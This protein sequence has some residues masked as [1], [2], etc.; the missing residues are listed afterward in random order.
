MTSGHIRS[1]PPP[2]FALAHAICTKALRPLPG[3]LTPWHV[4]I[5]C[6]LWRLVYP[7][8]IDVHRYELCNISAF[9]IHWCLFILVG[10]EIKIYY[11]YY[12]YYYYYIHN[13]V[14]RTLWANLYSSGAG[15]SIVPAIDGAGLLQYLTV[16][17][18]LSIAGAGFSNCSSY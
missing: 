18:N 9:V 4:F 16:L 11:Y 5:L 10:G 7:K 6:W 1:S 14:Y 3:D 13:S 12:Y 17:S 15:F 8:I 2:S